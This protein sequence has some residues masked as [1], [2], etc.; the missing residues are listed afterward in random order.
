MTDSLNHQ[1]L[2]QLLE[3]QISSPG[4]TITTTITRDYLQKLTKV[5]AAISVHSFGNVLIYPWGYKVISEVVGDDSL[6]M[7]TVRDD[8]LRLDTSVTLGLKTR[9]SNTSVE[10][11]LLPLP[12]TS[13]KRSSV[14]QV[15][16]CF[17]FVLWS[18]RVFL[19]D[20]SCFYHL[21][22]SR[23]GK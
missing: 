20:S 4:I 12:T 16:N 21:K 14:V 8:S 23:T 6:R 18:E 15:K 13:A 17:W 22:H 3:Y 19:V 7:D 10:F 5:Q 2:F 11:P 1:G 9:K